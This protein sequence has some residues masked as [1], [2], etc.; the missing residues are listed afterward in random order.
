LVE[1]FDRD[2]KSFS[3]LRGHFTL[4]RDDLA[5]TK[6][7]MLKFR[8]AQHDWAS[9]FSL[10]LSLPDPMRPPVDTPQDPVAREPQ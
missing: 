2:G 5:A 6:D 3:Q 9:P 4:S 1:Q 8:S 7:T 10:R